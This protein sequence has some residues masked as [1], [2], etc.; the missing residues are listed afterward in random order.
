MKDRLYFISDGKP[1]IDFEVEAEAGH[2]VVTALF[3]PAAEQDVAACDTSDEAAGVMQDH[4][5]A[6]FRHHDARLAMIRYRGDLRM[7]S[8]VD[9]GRFAVP[10]VALPEP[11]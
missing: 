11:D 1:R 2:I 9:L 6:H 4:V 5:D 7:M 3:H 10:I 8:L